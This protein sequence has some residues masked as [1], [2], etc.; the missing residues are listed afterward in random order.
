MPDD[1]ANVKLTLE[2]LEACNKIFEKGFLSHKKI[3]DL[4]SEVLQSIS[5]GFSYFVRWHKVLSSGGM[6]VIAVMI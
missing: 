1:A 6:Y 3:C 5:T 4:N 2:Y